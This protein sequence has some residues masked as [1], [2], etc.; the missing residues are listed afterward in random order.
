M[1]KRTIE[2]ANK[3]RYDLSLV[4]G[5][6]LVRRTAEHRTRNFECRRLSFTS[7][8]VIRCRSRCSLLPLEASARIRL[9]SIFDIQRLAKFILDSRDIAKQIP[10]WFFIPYLPGNAPLASPLLPGAKGLDISGMRGLN[11][12]ITGAYSGLPA[13]LVCSS[14]STLWSYN[15]S[16]P[17]A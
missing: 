9:C 4:R 14:G 11:F 17:S 16:D 8:F 5:S 6:V 1:S 2:P 12:A 10:I 7:K 15:S 3:A 13:R